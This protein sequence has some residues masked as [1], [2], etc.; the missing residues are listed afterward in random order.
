MELRHS[1]EG[2][3]AMKNFFMLISD[4]KDFMANEMNRLFIWV[5]VLN[6]INLGFIHYEVK[7]LKELQVKENQKMLEQLAHVRKRVDY[8]YFNMTRTF[9]DLYKIK[10]NTLDGELK[11]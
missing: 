8:R 6:I 2:Y 9:E 5:L 10:I 3:V 1:N 11:H 4:A 7:S